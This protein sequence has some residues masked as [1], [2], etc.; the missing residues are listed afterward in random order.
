MNNFEENF[1]KYLDIERILNEFFNEFDFCF[2]RCVRLEMEINGNNPVAA[3]CQDKYYKVYDL[4]YPSFDLLRDQR[5]A[6]YGE[7]S[8][9]KDSS[10]VSPCE[11]HTSTGCVLKTHK[12]PICLSFFC[13]KGIDFLRKNYNIFEYDYLGMN[14]ALEWI[15]TGDLQEKDYVTFRES[16]MT[17]LD[18]IK[19]GSR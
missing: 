8:D 15:L 10:T 19:K 6:L 17:M 18:K 14:Y 16:C 13:R 3:C 11:Y 12:S 4:E 2:S 5:E 9:I 7:P 1:N